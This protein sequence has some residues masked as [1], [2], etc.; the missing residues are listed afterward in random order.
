MLKIFVSESQL[1]KSDW[2]VA[3]GLLFKI[4][5]VNTKF[6]ELGSIE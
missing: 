5:Y 1:M 3:S 6:I 2:K 4:S